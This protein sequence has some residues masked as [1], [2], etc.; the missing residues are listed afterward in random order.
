LSQEKYLQE[1][2]DSYQSA[3]YFTFSTNL[4][5][6]DSPSKFVLN[7][8]HQQNKHPGILVDIYSLA[9]GLFLSVGSP[10]DQNRVVANS[11]TAPTKKFLIVPV[12]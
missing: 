10:Q 1:E 12:E 9:N 3:T 11:R 2:T 4:D 6:D 7:Y 5:L 8:N